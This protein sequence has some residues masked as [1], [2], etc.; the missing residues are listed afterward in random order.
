MSEIK[1]WTCDAC[2]IEDHFPRTLD[3]KEVTKGKG[4][5]CTATWY[6]RY[7]DATDGAGRATEW[8]VRM[9]HSLGR[10]PDEARKH[11]REG[12]WLCGNCAEAAER[13]AGIAAMK[14]LTARGLPTHEVFS[15]RAACV[16]GQAGKNALLRLIT[17]GP[18][19]LQE[20]EDNPPP[21]VSE[22]EVTHYIR[23]LQYDRKVML[24]DF[25]IIR[26]DP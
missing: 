14:V 1:Y 18:R 3:G 22:K 20:L 16:S 11:G 26:E 13:A 2:G 25:V 10:G 9:L 21:G 23:E 15:T 24:K 6:S 12:I 8:L 4:V 17:Q 19:T 7:F 5:R